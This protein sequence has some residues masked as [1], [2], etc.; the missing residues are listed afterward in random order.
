MCVKYNHF[1][2]E[3][4]VFFPLLQ[5]VHDWATSILNLDS[6]VKREKLKIIGIIFSLDFFPSNTTSFA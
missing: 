4:L 5:I 2:I 3:G 6:E 1:K